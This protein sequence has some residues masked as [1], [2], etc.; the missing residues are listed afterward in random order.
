MLILQLQLEVFLESA[1]GC[2]VFH[3]RDLQHP[4]IVAG[5]IARA[6]ALTMPIL[7]RHFRWLRLEPCDRNVC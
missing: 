3:V 7:C 1:M 2:E 6:I 5:V 4:V